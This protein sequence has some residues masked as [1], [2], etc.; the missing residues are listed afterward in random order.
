MYQV[1]DSETETHVSH[2]RKSNPYHPD[3][4]VVLRGWKYQ[5]D[6]HGTSERFEG[7]TSD[8]YLRIRPETT[9][10]VGHNIKFDLLYELANDNPDLKAFFKRG[11]KV[12]D[13]Q[14]AEYLLGGMTQSVQM[15]AMDAIIEKYGGRKKINGLKAMW[16]AGILT[17]NIDPDMLND[18]LI[19][20]EA[21]GRNS[22]DI[23]NTEL[24]FLGQI[25]QAV[26]D[27]MLQSIQFRMDGLLCTTDMEHNGI[28]VD[29]EVAA[30]NLTTL[31]A[32]MAGVEKELE[33]Y[34][35]AIPDCVDFSWTRGVC[36]SAMMFGGAIPFKMQL[37]YKDD[38]GEWA[39]KNEIQKWPLFDGTPIDPK[40]CFDGGHIHSEDNPTFYK[41]D[42][43]LG[44]RS[45]QE[46]IWQ[47]KFLSGKK[48][49]EPKF[50]N[51]K[52][53]GE[54][55]VRYED[56]YYTLDGY[57]TPEPEWKTKHTDALGDPVYGS[58]SEVIERVSK[59][60]IP[61]LKAMGKLQ[62][63]NKEIGTYYLRYDES[64]KE[65][66]GMLT[67]VQ[68][69]DHI[70]HHS[71]NHT[72]TKTSRL[73]ANNPN[74]QNLTRADFDAETGEY[75][76]R[77]KEM[78]VSR[79]GANGR[80]I[81]A[82]YSQLEVVVQGLLTMDKNLIRDLND[83]VDFHCKRV[84]LKNGITYEQALEWCKDEN[85]PDHAKWKKERTRCKI[86][87]FQRA[88]GAGAALIAEDTGMDVEEVKAL[89]VE[90]DK[91]YP[92]VPKFN[93]AVEA[94]VMATAE[95]F[96]D[97]ERGFRTFRKGTWQA[98]TGTV[99]SFRSWDAKAWQ[100]KKGITDSFSPTEMKN[101]PVQ[102]TGGELVQMV[103]GRL[104]RMF[105]AN[106]NYGG[107]AFLVN[108]VHDCVWIDAHEDVYKQVAADI[109]PVMESITEI[110]ENEFGIPCPVRFPVDVEQGMNMLEMSHV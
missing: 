76:S 3:N 71:L 41:Y 56:F 28:K 86:F 102:G 69:S 37:P 101:Y 18:Y 88:Y 53:K 19:G 42:D 31:E 108:T 68:P 100:R 44:P 73:S 84:A 72:S 35:T 25:Q 5:G 34:A 97:K 103:L 22:G 26:A 96:R 63:L 43:N 75:K 94:E 15:V 90:E 106:D 81:E 110:L 57:T 11:G 2:K 51:V 59:R 16:D 61:F 104:W 95:F 10:L 47:D 21:E 99:Y 62:T 36:I 98:P 32:D 14:Y 79:F 54:L 70:V 77:V 82:D 55:K 93:A 109:K 58:G 13:T 60:D 80:M 39:R 85:H 33:Q 27:E 66:K 29:V 92:G 67:C 6:S 7:K 8:N 48:K 91:E 46:P 74:C 78:F 23:T 17:S 107:K 65:Y 9:I 20:T 50:K 89:I 64:S 105:V 12:W 24:I 1:F 40:D 52:V 38:N 4:Y 87:S 30:R 45:D 83:K 49:G